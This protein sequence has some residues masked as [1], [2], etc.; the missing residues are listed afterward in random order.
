MQRADTVEKPEIWER[1][2]G[3]EKTKRVERA[4][5]AEC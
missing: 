5:R 4:D 3:S 2:E 1:S